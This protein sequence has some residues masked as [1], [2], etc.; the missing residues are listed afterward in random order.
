MTGR[1]MATN[2][3]P[4]TSISRTDAASQ[5]SEGTMRFWLGDK[6]PGRIQSACKWL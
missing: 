6:S 3:A 5:G 2:I 1:P 4:P